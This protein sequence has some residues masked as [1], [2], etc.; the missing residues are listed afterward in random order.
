VLA[1]FKGSRGSYPAHVIVI[2]DGLAGAFELNAL[3]K[4]QIKDFIF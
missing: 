1:I 2:L 3:P 4:E